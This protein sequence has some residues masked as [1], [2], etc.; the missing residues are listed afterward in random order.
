MENEEITEMLRGNDN[1]MEYTARIKS[2]DF[3]DDEEEE[4]TIF[5]LELTEP[6]LTHRATLPLG[7]SQIIRE[8][9][10]L[11]NWN[12]EIL[13]AVYMYCS[14]GYEPITGLTETL[15]PTSLVGEI[16]MFEFNRANK[17]EDWQLIKMTKFNEPYH[18]NDL[19][20]YHGTIA[21]VSSTNRTIEIVLKVALSKM[22]QSF[23]LG[24]LH[25]VY[26]YDLQNEEQNELFLN[27][28]DDFIHFDSYSKKFRFSNDHLM[29]IEPRKEVS[30]LSD[31]YVIDEHDVRPIQVCKVDWKEKVDYD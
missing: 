14:D 9:G 30:Q 13:E 11:N 3:G 26:H 28:F 23:Y 22:T 5:H 21:S 4:K 16:F 12:H 2:I 10:D 20:T 19:A 27:T 6:S 24:H 15:N 8:S 25:R 17:N 1:R 7:A 31:F 29:I 18:S